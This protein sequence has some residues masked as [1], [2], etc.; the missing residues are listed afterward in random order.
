MNDVM[1]LGPKQIG[2]VVDVD[3][4]QQDDGL[5]VYLYHSFIKIGFIVTDAVL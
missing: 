5:S 2:H 4:S 1:I 3:A